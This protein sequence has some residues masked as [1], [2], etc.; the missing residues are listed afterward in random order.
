M[1]HLHC[2]FKCCKNLDQVL[3]QMLLEIMKEAFTAKALLQTGFRLVWSILCLSNT[4]ANL[5]S[6][7]TNKHEKHDSGLW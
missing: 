2:K 4:N 1:Q 5:N 6:E 3:S 7:Q